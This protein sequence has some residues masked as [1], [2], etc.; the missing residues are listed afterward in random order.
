M[1]YILN[2]TQKRIAPSW[3]AA[4][5]LAFSDAVEVISWLRQMTSRLSITPCA[6]TVFQNN[7]SAIEWSTA[8]NVKQISRRKRF[9]FRYNFGTHEVENSIVNLG[10]TRADKTKA[11]LFTKPFGPT[12]FK[13]TLGQSSIFVTNY[14]G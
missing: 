14:C 13:S 8:E 6:T 7:Q 11:N 4:E 3:T 12:Q 9:D 1:I 5:H 2:N 10:N